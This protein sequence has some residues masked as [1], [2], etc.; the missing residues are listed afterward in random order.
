MKKKKNQVSPK[1]AGLVGHIFK[2]IFN[3]YSSYKREA[4]NISLCACGIWTH[5]P[6]RSSLLFLFPN[7][8]HCATGPH[9]FNGGNSPVNSLCH[10]WYNKSNDHCWA[11]TQ[12]FRFT[13]QHFTLEPPGQEQS[14]N[15]FSDIFL[16]WLLF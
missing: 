14:V 9:I 16:V 6:D 4:S 2:G 1:K 5:N 15:Y 3:L 13:V 7:I 8:T 12:T 11:G 10:S